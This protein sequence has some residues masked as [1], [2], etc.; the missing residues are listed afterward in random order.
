MESSKEILTELQEIAPFLGKK[1]ISKIPYSVPYGYFEEFIES[2]LNRIRQEAAGPVLEAAGGELDDLSPQQEIDGISPLIA[3]IK[4]KNPY[5][6]PDGYFAGWAPKIPVLS[7]LETENT[8]SELVEM[9]SEQSGTEA[10]IP[11]IHSIRHPKKHRNFS[12][13]RVIRYA[14]AACIIGLLGI[15]I[16]NMSN[17]ITS[18]P[19]NGLTAVTD[20]DLSSYLDSGAIQVSP[21]IS[22]YAETASLDFSDN[23]VHELL[24]SVPDAELEQYSPALA[25]QKPTVN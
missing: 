21:D 15:G 25:A 23:D 6:A 18:D 1:G 4:R 12:T 2:L 19:I 22:S 9:A 20:L 8:L 13:L 10:A 11:Q 24:I 5:R 16:Y 17:H 14:A 7:V 3:G